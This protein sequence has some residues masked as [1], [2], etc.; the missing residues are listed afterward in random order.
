MQNAVM[1]MLLR[2]A[3]LFE[4]RPQHLATMVWAM[5]VARVEAHC[6]HAVSLDLLGTLQLLGADHASGMVRIPSNM[7]AT[8]QVSLP[9]RPVMLALGH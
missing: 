8:Q 1:Q 9:D 4:T 7:L 5:A 6:D 3:A 2:M